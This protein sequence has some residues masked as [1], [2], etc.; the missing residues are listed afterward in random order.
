VASGLKQQ[1]T[2]ALVFHG[3]FREDLKLWVDGEEAQDF[4]M[5]R[6]GARRAG[7]KLEKLCRE[8]N[9]LHSMEL[10][11][12]TKAKEFAAA[13]AQTRQEWLA[14]GMQALLAELKEE[15]GVEAQAGEEQ[16]P[17]EAELE[18]TLPPLY[19]LMV[20]DIGRILQLIEQQATARATELTSMAALEIG[21]A[22]ELVLRGTARVPGVEPP[23][24]DTTLLRKM[25]GGP[26]PAA[27]PAASAARVDRRG[28]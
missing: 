22:A 21:P 16:K 1:H 2:T 18:K 14:G 10:Q 8:C 5:A 4:T 3:A 9:N 23:D 13:A 25:G 26:E 17:G 28:R 20:E 19:E 24:A 11:G 7:T 15:E 12:Q 6:T 27:A